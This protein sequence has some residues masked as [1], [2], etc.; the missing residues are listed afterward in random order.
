MNQYHKIHTVFKRDETT[1]FKNLLF[2]EYSLPEFRYLATNDWVFTEKVDGTNIRVMYDGSEVTFGGKTDQAQIPA[3]LVNRL[4][5]LFTERLSLLNSVFKADSVC[6]YGEG[7]GPKIQKVG[8][9]YGPAQ[10]FVLFDIKI[11]P[12]WLRREDI[13]DIAEQLGIGSVPI[14]GMG[15]LDDMVNFVKAKPRSIWG[16]F[17]AEGVVARPAVE[18]FSRSGS[19]IITKLKVRDFEN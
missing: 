18:L 19:R 8:S 5:V 17:V 9:L 2:G 1:K 3:T 16:D 6:L 13:F 15:T 10:D 14:V 12:Y 4:N 11:G 7:Y